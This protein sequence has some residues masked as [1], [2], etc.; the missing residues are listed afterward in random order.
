MASPKVDWAKYTDEQESLASKV[1]NLGISQPTTTPQDGSESSKS[2][3]TEDQISPAEKS[4]LQKIIRK[5]LVETTKDLEIQRKDPTS[6]LY[7]IKTFEALHLKP[8]LL[9]GVYAMGFNAPSKI[10][11]TA[12]PTLL[13]DPPQNMIAQSQSGTGKTAAFVLAM[14]S[15]V[16]PNKDYPQVLCLSPT[17]ELAIQTGEVAAK[18]SQFCPEIKLKY[19][20]RGE[21]IARGTKITDHI[22]IGTPGKVLDWAIKFRFFDL[23]KISVF[24]LDEADV[25]IATQGHQDQCIRIHKLLPRTCQMMFFS[26]TYETAVMEFAE[27]IVSNPL[28]IRLLKEEESLDNIKQYYVKCKNMDE[29]YTAITNIYGVITIGQAIIFCHT[30][31]TA[32]WLAEKMSKD[33]HAVAVLSGDLT[34]EQRIAVLDRFRAGLEKVLITT[35]VLARGIDVE[36]V[37]IVVNFDLPIDQDRQADCATYLHRIGRTGRFGKSGIAINLVDSSH[38]MQVCQDIEKHFGK[39]IHYLDAEDAEEIEKIGA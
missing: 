34:V 2:D 17:Y 14:L 4:L 8:A 28:I 22:I 19:A 35:N 21:E 20:V 31:K 39:K 13:A 25:M 10:Q 9:K 6:P 7:S 12:L 24:V 1:T 3:E 18:M 11:E 38:A 5:G 27:I 16:D 26:A 33:G 15:R 30:R 32:G 23:R 29:K 36:Q 37:T